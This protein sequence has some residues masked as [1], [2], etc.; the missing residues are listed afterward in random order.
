MSRAK[1]IKEKQELQAKLASAFSSKTA[2]VLSWLANDGDK[3]AEKISKDTAVLSDARK[4]FFSLPVVATGAGLSFDDEHSKTADAA[5]HEDIAT[6]GEFIKSNKKIS[7]LAKKKMQKSNPRDN[8]NSTVYRIQKDDSKAT[9]ALKNKLRNTK[10]NDLR[11]QIQNGQSGERSYNG[12]K[13]GGNI[14]S[15]SQRQ[16]AESDD[17]EEDYE[18]IVQKTTKKSGAGP[19]QFGKKKK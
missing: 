13:N 8:L 5:N 1:E 6:V 10:R 9:I 17:D 18:Q 14:G 3:A 7:T 12:R 19:L 15:R 2:T 4:D 16:A 11:N